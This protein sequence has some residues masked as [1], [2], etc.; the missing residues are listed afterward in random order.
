[1]Q[2]AGAAGP[3][4]F[5]GCCQLPSPCCAHP[6]WVQL[7]QQGVL[8]LSVTIAVVGCVGTAFWAKAAVLGSAAMTCAFP[9]PGSC[10]LCSEIS[11]RPEQLLR[12]LSV[13]ICLQMVVSSPMSCCSAKSGSGVGGV[14][15]PCSTVLPWQIAAEASQSNRGLFCCINSSVC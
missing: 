3:V 8:E 10:G 7:L 14:G 15:Q 11:V 9:A 6:P 12:S 2:G 4:L 1:M 5:V 13:G